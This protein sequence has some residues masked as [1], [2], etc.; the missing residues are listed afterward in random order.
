MLSVWDKTMRN[1]PDI[2]T[3]S[4][5]AAPAPGP[6]VAPDDAPVVTLADQLGEVARRAIDDGYDLD[7]FMQAAWSAYVESRPGLREHLE[8]L[9][10]IA[11][12]DEMR[13]RGLVGTA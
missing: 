11:G 12:L 13:K 1:Q 4:P 10:V 6:A 3:L 9:R 8:E 5:V 2:E 7:K